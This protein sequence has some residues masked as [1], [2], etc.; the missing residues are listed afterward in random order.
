MNRR[1]LLA[2]ISL[3][4]AHAANAACLGINSG[5]VLATVGGCVS[6]VAGGGGVISVVFS[7][8]PSTLNQYASF[9]A[10]ITISGYSV[11]YVGAIAAGTE[12]G[13]RYPVSATGTLPT[14][15]G[16]SGS[17]SYQIGAWD[18]P[19]GGTQLAVSSTITVTA[20]P[21]WATPGNLVGLWD[22]SGPSAPS[23]SAIT[24]LA[25]TS[26]AG[27]AATMVAGSEGYGMVVQGWKIGPRYNGLLSGMLD[28]ALGG[29][30]WAGSSQ[31][32]PQMYPWL[33]GGAR[34]SVPNIQLGS[35]Q[36]WS[37]SLIF[38]N[39]NRAQTDAGTCNY[40]SG[41]RP[42]L[43]A[44][45]VTIADL[46][47]NGSSA[48]NTMKLFPA[49]A[50]IS[51]STSVPSRFTYAL[52][53]RN[54]PGTG[55][56]AWLNGVQVAT[57]AANPFA[58]SLSTTLNV[59]SDGTNSGKFIFHTLAVYSKALTSGDVGN[60]L[61]NGLSAISLWQSSVMGS[62][63]GARGGL[64][65]I[66][67]GQSNM[68]YLSIGGQNGAFG[69][70]GSG[71]MN[72]V[73]MIRAMTGSLCCVPVA[74]V[75][76][77]SGGFL[78]SGT[79]FYG[80]SNAIFSST[81][82]A[83]STWPLGTGGTSF[84]S[85]LN[86]IKSFP[87]MADLQFMSLFAWSENNG[88]LYGTSTAGTYSSALQQ[89]MLLM[90]S[91]LYP[92]LS[93]S[94][95][96]NS[97]PMFVSTAWA[98]NGY[99]SIGNGLA[100]FVDLAVSQAIAS[101]QNIWLGS[102]QMQDVIPLGSTWNNTN[103]TFTD[104]TGAGVSGAHMDPPNCDAQLGI[105]MGVNAGV[106]LI[107]QNY[108][109]FTAAPACVPHSGGPS[110]SSIGL[111]GN[112]LTIGI[113]HDGGTDVGLALKALTGAGWA[114][115]DGVTP[116]VPGGGSTSGVIYAT[117]A[118]RINAT[119]IQVTLASTPVNPAA[120]GLVYYSYG[121]AM[122]GGYG[123]SG[124]YVTNSLTDNSKTSTKPVGWNFAGSIGMSSDLPLQRA[125]GVVA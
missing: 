107:T 121:I 50:N 20:A 78:F 76:S 87:D 114:Y 75:A 13:G 9:G 109:Q 110:I 45:G 56:D 40:Q 6:A 10:T 72:A 52:T 117:A 35:G 47:N 28:Q 49:G 90:R 24:S 16:P 118:A 123:V 115:L 113:T 21:T 101:G 83:P 112:V 67:G 32:R 54:T 55:V 98:Y 81:S 64:G 59:V 48:A 85:A 80:T 30:D 12:E 116:D 122:I 33:S 86:Y 2:G 62:S 125:L 103:G 100:F 96:T 23:S 71:L 102:A 82:G 19:Y 37:L 106:R 104:G 94:A 74:A 60:L 29:T 57:A 61:T 17:G 14:K 42:I 38:S 108:T 66:V 58:S 77:G 46:T 89:Y 84:V 95:L 36:P 44:G 65:A 91:T 26:G 111:S 79:N 99:G 39:P 120:Q 34:M 97:V 27:S 7:A 43:T 41:T 88:G 4:A 69:L 11:C 119:T 31:V 51:L 70:P 18:S 73:E 124:A 63:L 93:G 5:S 92:S 1:A 105:R 15:I 53:L 22:A 25:D 3:F 68:S 8:V